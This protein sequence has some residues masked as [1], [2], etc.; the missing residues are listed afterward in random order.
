M[1]NKDKMREDFE[2]WAIGA[3]LALFVNNNKD[4]GYRVEIQCAWMAWQASREALCIRLPNTIDYTG[5]NS[6]FHAC[7]EAIKSQGVPT[8]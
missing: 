6:V 8:K 5:F 7:R 1:N 3:G 4:C 2:V